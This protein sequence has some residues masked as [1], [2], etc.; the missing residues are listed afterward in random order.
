MLGTKVAD[1][2]ETIVPVIRQIGMARRPSEAGGLIVP[3]PTADV[4]KWVVEL[5]NISDEP[6]DSFF[7]DLAKAEEEVAIQLRITPDPTDVWLW[8]TH[9][10]GNVGPSPMDMRGKIDGVHYLVVALPDGPAVR[11]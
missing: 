2:L 9:P 10:G 11:Y 1:N 6:H 5:E 4:H 7:T 3:T 8:H